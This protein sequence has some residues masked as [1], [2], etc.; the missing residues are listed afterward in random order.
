MRPYNVFI[1]NPA[2]EGLTTTP[3]PWYW[4]VVKLGFE[5]TPASFQGPHAEAS[6]RRLLT[7]L[8]TADAPHPVLCTFLRNQMVTYPERSGRTVW[9][10]QPH[11]CKDQSG[12]LPRLSSMASAPCSLIPPAA[13]SRSCR[14]QRRLKIFRLPGPRKD[15][16]SSLFW[17]SHHLYPPLETGTPPPPDRS[18]LW[19]PWY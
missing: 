11:H 4:Q 18:A 5:P 8:A 10:S 9:N 12:A 14:M 16:A 2:P 19:V 6:I 3:R 13:T 15:A 1:I 7:S 17:P